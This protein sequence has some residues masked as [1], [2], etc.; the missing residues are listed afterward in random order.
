MDIDLSTSLDSFNFLIDEIK[1]GADIA[2]GSRYLAKSKIKRSIKRYVLSRIYHIVLI[3]FFLKL[4]IKDVQCGF[5][6]ISNNAFKK[7][8]SEYFRLRFFL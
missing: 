4:P 1:K 8:S 2:V 5:K 7:L 3:N 6:A